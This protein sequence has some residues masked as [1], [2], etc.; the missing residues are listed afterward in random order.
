[1]IPKTQARLTAGS[2]TGG[3][4]ASGRRRRRR[5]HQ[6]LLRRRTRRDNHHWYYKVI[7]CRIAARH[8]SLKSCLANS[9]RVVVKSANIVI[10]QHNV[11]VLRQ[12]LASHNK[13]LAGNSRTRWVISACSRTN[14]TSPTECTA[15]IHL[16]EQFLNIAYGTRHGAYSARPRIPKGKPNSNPH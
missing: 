11:E 2:G 15:V 12:Y 5:K 3:A 6:Q 13:N 8:I 9:S 14:T 7:L 1:M 16:A 10:M 4:S